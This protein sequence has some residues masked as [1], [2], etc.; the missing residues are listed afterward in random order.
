MSPVELAEACA[1][2]LWEHDT[3]SRSAGM[4][5]E[6]VAPG[7]ARLVLEIDEAMTNGHGIAHGGV[8]FLLADTAFAF[9]CNTYDDVTVAQGADISFVEPA[10][11]GDRLVAEAREVVRRGRSGVYDVTV[12]RDGSVVAV[13]RGRSRSLGRPLLERRGGVQ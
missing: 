13:F 1:A 4:A 10:Y 8:V 5:L 12:T 7:Y 2:Y 9:A 11:V 6:A 3:A